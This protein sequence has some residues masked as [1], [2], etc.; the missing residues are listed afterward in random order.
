MNRL[1]CIGKIFFRSF[2]KVR[3]TFY[4]S[5]FPSGLSHK[6]PYH[7]VTK[8]VKSLFFIYFL[9]EFFCSTFFLEEE[10]ARFFCFGIIQLFFELAKTEI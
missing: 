6:Q 7:W 5:F 3:F 2:V 10:A 4:H 9:S 1:A 8:E